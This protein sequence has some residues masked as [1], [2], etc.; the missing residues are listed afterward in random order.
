LTGGIIS[1]KQTSGK[2]DL[3]FR[4]ED[5]TVNGVIYYRCTEIGRQDIS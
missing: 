1:R 5:V 2:K 3:T 4:I